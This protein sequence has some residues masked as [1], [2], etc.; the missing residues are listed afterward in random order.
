MRR[1]HRRGGTT[2]MIDQEGREQR[3]QIDNG[4]YEQPVGRP[5]IGPGAS[6]DPTCEQKENRAASRDDRA[7]RRTDEAQYPRQLRGEN[8][9]SA[10]DQDLT[11]RYSA[12]RDNRQHRYACTCIITGA[13]EREGPEVRRRPEEDNEKQRQRL[14]P[15]V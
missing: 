3:E 9:Q 10:I 2:S 7:I 4:K 15:D 1:T 6:V 12:P 13:V 11:R 8:H 5:A 14:E